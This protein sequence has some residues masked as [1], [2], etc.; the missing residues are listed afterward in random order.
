MLLRFKKN[1][2]KIAMGLLSFMPLQKDVKVLQ[3]T[4]NQ[5]ETNPDWHLLLWKENEDVIGA[6]GLKIDNDINAVIQHISVNPSYRNAGIGKKMIKGVIEMY[7][8]EYDVCANENI[9]SFYDKCLD[10][11]EQLDE[12]DND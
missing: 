8:K 7:G 10:D 1:Y 9:E 12:T 4:M 11:D 6:V 3:E 5:Y 2:E